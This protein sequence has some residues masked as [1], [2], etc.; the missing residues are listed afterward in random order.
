MDFAE[1]LG[2]L[3]S[4]NRLCT[5]KD[6]Q[7]AAFEPRG[8]MMDGQRLSGARVAEVSRWPNRREQLSLLLGQILSPGANLV[9]Q[10]T[11]PGAVLTGQIHRQAEEE[12]A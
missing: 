3:L 7:F 12:G 11:G 6:E 9:G 2:R 1:D 8:G 4:K 5:L 10:L